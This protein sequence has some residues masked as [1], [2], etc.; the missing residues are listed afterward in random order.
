MAAEA[1]SEWVFR[2][3]TIMLPFYPVS[4]QTVLE[5][6]LRFAVMSAFALSASGASA[7]PSQTFD[8]VEVRGAEFIPE[9]D[10]RMTCGAVANVPYFNFELRAI[11]DCLMSTGAFE[12]VELI[13][14][15][16]TLVIEVQELNTRP[17][18]IEASLNYA[19]QDG[20]IG[21]LFFE[22]Y[23]LLPDTYGAARLQ[24]NADVKR[25]LGR[26]YR[27]DVIGDSIDLGLRAGWEDVS[28]DDD[29]F[30]QET[31]QAEAYL[32][33]TL[34]DRMRLEAGLGYRDYRLFDVVPTASALLQ[35]EQ[36]SGVQAPYVRVGLDHSSLENGD[37][38]WGSWEYSV[39]LEHYFWNLGTNDRLSDFRLETR[40]YIPLASNLRMLIALDAR[41]ISSLDSNST[42]VMD[43]LA[44]GADGFRGFA[45]RGIGPRDGGV[46]LGGQK[47]FVSTIELQ[48]N[49]KDLF[50]APL[51]GGIFWQTGG[52]WELD[53]TL[54]GVIDDSFHQR[55][56]VGLS[57]SF[58]VG[59]SPVSVFV[60]FPVEKE[61]G[62]KEQVFGLSLST[63]F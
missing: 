24:Y 16:D 19:S 1:A 47:Y 60:A 50:D 45:P 46:A 10:I 32:S 59:K 53:D 44:P 54:G 14:E 27:V 52:A 40:S 48:R 35:A 29:S 23:N 26:L 2:R 39:G 63:Q 21:G 5:T 61:A 34:G 17:G 8:T 30:S 22:R 11:E 20:L 38:G 12:S 25:A 28:L 37:T 43:R 55:S 36:T 7:Q 58:E 6:T 41:T 57:L 42:R 62:D 51:V 4:F 18:R 49:L 13:P 31:Y 9:Q 56:S 33:W 3:K 15:N